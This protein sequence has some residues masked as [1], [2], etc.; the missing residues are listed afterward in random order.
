MLVGQEVRIDNQ[1]W[2][3]SDGESPAQDLHCPRDTRGEAAQARLG[4]DRGA[5]EVSWRGQFARCSNVST[6]LAGSRATL[7]ALTE[8]PVIA[9]SRRRNLLLIRT[10]G[11]KQ[12]VR[13][14]RQSSLSMR[15]HFRHRGVFELHGHHKW[16]HQPCRSHSS[17]NC[18]VRSGAA[19]TSHKSQST[20]CGGWKRNASARLKLDQRFAIEIGAQRRTIHRDHAR[21][22]RTAT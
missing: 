7:R 1:Q 19:M 10:D 13:Q 12:L 6:F 21:P 9:P 20:G 11:E 22:R 3:D 18:A 14:R 2:R 15:Q 16:R 17:N 8:V 4:L 5:K